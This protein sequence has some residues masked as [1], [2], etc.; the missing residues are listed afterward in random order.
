M[1]SFFIFPNQAIMDIVF[2]IDASKTLQIFNYAKVLEFIKAVSKGFTLSFHET[3]IGVVQFNEDARIM[4]GFYCCE[5]IKKFDSTVDRLMV[6]YNPPSPL[7]NAP[8]AVIGK[9]LQLAWYLFNGPTGRRFA[10]RVLVVVASV[11]SADDVLGPS[12]LLRDSGVEIFCVGVGKDY[13]KTEIL[14]IA[15]LPSFMH[16]FHLEGFSELQKR[17]QLIVDRIV[18][19]KLDNA[20]FT[21]CD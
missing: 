3:R 18:R 14:H 1:T 19:S 21:H 13:S 9:G 10:P 7:S 4:F 11:T 2:L 8:A 6:D 20:T 5:N 15:S 12:K 16:V 17:A